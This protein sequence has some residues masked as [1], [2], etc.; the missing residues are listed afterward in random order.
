MD[1]DILAIIDGQ[2]IRNKD[3]DSIIERYPT[4]KRIYFETEQGRK[5][6]LEQRVAFGLM[7]RKAKEEKIDQRKEF[8][9]KI[10]EIKEQ[11]LTQM[12]MSEIFADVNVTKEECK[13]NYEENKDAFVEEA[14]IGARH[15]LMEDEKKIKEVRDEILNGNITFEDAAAKYSICPSKE[16]GG[17][18]GLFK[19]GMMVKEFEDVAFE[20]PLNELSEAVKSQFGYHLI[21]VDEKREKRQ[22]PFEEAEKMLESQLLEQKKQKIYEVSLDEL[23]KKYN[24]KIFD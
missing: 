10:E 16:K 3:L 11:L 8:L 24:V 18:L 23:K 4:E 20:L 21:K 6:L 17:D 14:C 9:D 22:L 1:K 2:E 7:S 5:Q 12:V 13:E 15:I 19:K